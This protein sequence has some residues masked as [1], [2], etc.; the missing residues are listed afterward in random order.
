MPNKA[1]A[2]KALRQA[3]RRTVRNTK[4]K[5]GITYLERGYAKALVAKDAAK[6]QAAFRALQRALDRAAEKGVLKDNTASRMKS[7][8]VARLTAIA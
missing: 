3:K 7:R 5:D 8:A 2:W 1:A 4:V 6:A